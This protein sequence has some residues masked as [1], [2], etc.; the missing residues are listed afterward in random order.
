MC[1]SR[2]NQNTEEKSMN[3][4]LIQ[5]TYRGVLCQ[6]CRQPIPLPA[7]VLHIEASLHQT[8]AGLGREE[9][10]RVFSLRCRSC[11]KEMLYRMSDVA[12]IE[13]TP[14]PRLSRV[15]G[16]HGKQHADVS[17]AASA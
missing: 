10:G 17:R 2:E 9:G 8:D 1:P 15:N 16:A 7:I 5:Q 4:E 13:G 3:Q 12:V 11:E 14:K 6:C